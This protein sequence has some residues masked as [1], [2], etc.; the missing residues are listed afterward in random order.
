MVGNNDLNG[1]DLNGCGTGMR[2]AHPAVAIS[3]ISL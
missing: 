2:R 3:T 1:S